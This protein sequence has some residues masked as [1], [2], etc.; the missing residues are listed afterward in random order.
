MGPGRLVECIQF[1]FDVREPCKVPF[2]DEE[3]RGDNEL[4][5][6]RDP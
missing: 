4:L 2:N 5:S 1:G 3:E 6:E